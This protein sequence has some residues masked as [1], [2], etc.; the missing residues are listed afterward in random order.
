MRRRSWKLICSGPLSCLAFDCSGSLNRFQATEFWVDNNYVGVA[1]GPGEET[2]PI[3]LLPGKHTLRTILPNVG[4]SNS[5]GRHS[6][7]LLR[8]ATKA[9]ATADVAVITISNGTSEATCRAK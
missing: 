9:L 4:P 5:F 8:P 7:W 3:T 1:F 2:R 6:V